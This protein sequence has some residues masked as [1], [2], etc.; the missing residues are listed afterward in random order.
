M[1]SWRKQMQHIA[2]AL[3]RSA[4]M[5][6]ATKLEFQGVHLEIMTLLNARIRPLSNS[7]LRKVNWMPRKSALS[8]QRANNCSSA[9]HHLLKANAQLMC[10]HWLKNLRM[11]TRALRKIQ[12]T[13]KS[14]TMTKKAGTCS[15]LYQ[16]TQKLSSNTQLYVS[17]LRKT[18]S[19]RLSHARIRM[20]TNRKIVKITARRSRRISKS[21]QVIP[22]RSSACRNW[23]RSSWLYSKMSSSASCTTSERFYACRMKR[24]SD[25]SG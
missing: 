3:T 13:N 15:T 14:R 8:T 16:L 22:S 23:Q 2:A 10:L 17:S 5:K 20:K 9:N 12:M 11:K 18:L 1:S 19:R 24:S 6:I 21:L 4:L 7:R 25:L